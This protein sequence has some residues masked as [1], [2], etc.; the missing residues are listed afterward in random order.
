[1][2]GHEASIDRV[3]REHGYHRLPVARVVR[4]T[5]DAS[6]FVLDVPDDLRELFS[7]RPGQFCT[8]RVQI[9]GEDHVRSYSMS[10]APATDDD[11]VVTIKRVQGGLVS[12]WLLDHV[13]EG[14]VLEV[15]KPAGVFC[16]Q[17]SAAPVLG[18]CGGS[19][20]TPVMSITKQVL[21]TTGRRV[22]LFYANR[23]RDGV[24]FA[25]ALEH[26]AA[27]HPGRMRVRYHFDEEATGF[28]TDADVRDFVG[29]ALDGHVYIC[30]PGPFMDLV[31][32]AVRR[33]GVDD[34]RIFLERFLVE[35]QE[36]EAALVEPAADDAAV[37]RDVTVTL[38][39][40]TVVVKYQPG[41]TLLETARRG[42]LRPPFSCESGNCATCMALLTEGS[43]SMR[44]NNALTPEEV[45]QGWVLTCQS[46]PHGATVAVEYEAM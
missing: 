36:K 45:E 19:G 11:L 32:T 24:I 29:D 43:V 30:G 25:D 12:N 16:P 2:S 27:D 6:S 13:T 18:F 4:E 7:Y 10:S 20:I 39:G 31:E 38:A 34:E 1:M 40:K 42:G 9:D 37:P 33:L 46:L 28:V 14:S 21:A 8:F 17:E 22:R 23:G 15:T 41:D 35:Q 3:L 26:L 44:A 5:E